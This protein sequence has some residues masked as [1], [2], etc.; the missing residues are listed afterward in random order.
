M[1][2]RSVAVKVYSWAAGLAARSVESMELTLAVPMVV[3]WVA[4]MG[5][6]SV[7]HSV[8]RLVDYLVAT[9]AE[10]SAAWLVVQ[11]VAESVLTWAVLTVALWVVDWVARWVG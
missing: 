9:W 4:P 10:N 8:A 6:S 2:V 5:E 7:D 3:A 1:A 11:L